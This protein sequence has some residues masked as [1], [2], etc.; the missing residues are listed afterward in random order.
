MANLDLK[1]LFA[2]IT[3][4]IGVKKVQV[5]FTSLPAGVKTS[6]VNSKYVLLNWE[7]NNASQQTSDWTVTTSDYDG[8]NNNVTVTGSKA[9][10]STS[11]TVTLYLAIENGN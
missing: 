11:V 7:I 10:S 9:D 8:T 5:T 3:Q 6:K 1:Q 4:T 2:K